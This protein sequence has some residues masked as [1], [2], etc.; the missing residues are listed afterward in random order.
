MSEQVTTAAA[1]VGECNADIGE[2]MEV[3]AATSSWA[4]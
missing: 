4:A 3:S 1:R 2:P